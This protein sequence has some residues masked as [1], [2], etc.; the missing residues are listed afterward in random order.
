MEL[1]FTS[2]EEMQEFNKRIKG[3][4]S[5]K[6]GDGDGEPQTGAQTGAMTGQAPAPLAPPVAGVAF[7]PGG[8]APAGFP[9]AAGFPGGGAPVLD[10]AVAALVA[11]INAKIDG[12]VAGGQSAEVVL[13]WFRGQCGPEAAGATMD[14]IKSVFLPKASMPTLEQIAKLMNA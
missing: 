13:N 5:G 8:A 4:R 1:R 11:R 2:I 14:Q 7:N 3:Q 9:G 12:A 6:A 10:P